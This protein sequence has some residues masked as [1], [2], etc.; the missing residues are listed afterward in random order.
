MIWAN[1]LHIYQPP[2]WKE[3]IINKVVRESYQPILNILK[4]NKKIKITLNINASL[5]EQLAKKHKEI[6]KQIKELAKRGQIEF[7]HSA[8]Y[9]LILPLHK[10]K[11]IERQII[12]NK[13]T[14]QKY[15][16]NLFQPKGFFQPEMAW[17]ENLIPILKKLKVEW[18]ALDEIAYSGQIGKISFEKGYQ[19]KKTKIYALFRNR[20]ISDFFIFGPEKE[21]MKKFLQNIENEKRSKNFLITAMDGENLGHHRPGMDKIWGKLLKKKGIESTNYSDLIKK[22]KSFEKVEPIPSS[23]SSEPMEIKAGIPYSLWQNPENPIHQKEWEL[24][25]KVIRLFN[26]AK[27]R[28]DKKLPLAQNLLDRSLASDKF[29]WASMRP[30]WDKEIIIRES[31]KLY[32]VIALLQSVNNKEKEEVRQIL[33][34]IVNLVNALQ[35]SGKAK[36]I[37]REYLKKIGFIPK[38]G[39]KKII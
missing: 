2:N 34:E 13:E 20:I 35:K 39:G 29:W 17:G 22:Y 28:K 3:S 26:Q 4:R 37:I 38:L 33:K 36:K 10:Q 16:G 24:T 9:H 12:L 5:T 25:K 14:N 15:F 7:T 27:K 23:W 30:W 11:I 31:K 21:I 8:K 32:Q 6:I 19:I 18:I 1:L